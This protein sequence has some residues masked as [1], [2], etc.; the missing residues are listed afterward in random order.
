[1]VYR[2]TAAIVA[3]ALFAAACSGA[4]SVTT[5]V[6]QSSTTAVGPTTTIDPDQD[7]IFGSGSVPDTVPADF[8]FPDEAVIGSTLIDRTRNVTEVIFRVPAA[9]E[10]LAAFFE[11]NLPG[12]GYTVGASSGGDSS[13]NIE[14]SNG[15]ATG[16]IDITLGGE[17]VAQAVVRITA[18]G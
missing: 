13:W 10:A 3:L 14:F 12:R 16:T 8:P 9:V 4:G 1:M 6:G 7:I 15:A 18:T 2:I 5:E 11:T 17:S